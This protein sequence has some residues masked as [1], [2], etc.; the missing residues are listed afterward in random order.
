MVVLLVV[1]EGGL[2]ISRRAGVSERR[3]RATWHALP[4]LTRG[5]HVGRARLQ[6]R[7]LE[8]VVRTTAN[9]ACLVQNQSWKVNIVA[10]TTSTCC[11][12]SPK[13][14]VTFHPH[15]FV[16]QQVSKRST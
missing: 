7:T 2:V 13:M 11:Q 15:R 4:G 16:M 3:G 10:C 6:G 1:G 9:H 14:L 12:I 5:A 8:S